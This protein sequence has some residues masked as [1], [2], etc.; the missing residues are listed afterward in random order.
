MDRF[1]LELFQQF[2]TPILDVFFKYFTQL[3]NHGELWIV[4]IIILLCFKSTRKIG[5]LAAI[6]LI[7]EFILVDFTI[8]PLIMRLRPFQIHNYSL[9]IPAPSGYSFPSGHTAS[10]FAVAGV[11]W[12]TH[13]RFRKTALL[14]ASLMALSRLYLMVH[15]PSDV[16]FGLIIGLSLA[17]IVVK[18]ESRLNNNTKPSL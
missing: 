11:L 3:G 10:S 16:L 12:F 9:I 17:Y 5:I 8:K 14:A 2:Q 4:T 15:W 18:I 6:A 13:C 7:V 1:I